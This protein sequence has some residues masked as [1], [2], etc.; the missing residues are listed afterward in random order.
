[1]P[2]SAGYSRLGIRCLDRSNVSC[3]ADL[4][5]CETPPYGQ[6][7]ASIAR[8]ACLL[9]DGLITRTALAASSTVSVDFGQPK[10]EIATTVSARAIVVAASSPAQGCARTK[11]TSCVG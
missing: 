1:V 8:P 10:A 4:R 9:I 7:S 2:L 11:E 6:A 5:V 3:E